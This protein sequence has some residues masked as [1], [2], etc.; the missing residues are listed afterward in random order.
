VNKCNFELILPDFISHD[1][2]LPFHYFPRRIHVI[3][4][5]VRLH[6]IL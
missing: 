6:R 1:M 4:L 3:G 2:Q 5:T